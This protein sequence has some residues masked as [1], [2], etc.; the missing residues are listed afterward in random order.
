MHPFARA[1]QTP[2]RGSCTNIRSL[3]LFTFNGRV[4]IA[5]GDVGISTGNL[6]GVK[7]DTNI[8]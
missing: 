5:S 3:R 6:S 7:E 8:M 2:T 1:V 4:S